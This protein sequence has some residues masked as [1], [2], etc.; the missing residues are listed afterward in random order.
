MFNACPD[1]NDTASLK[2][3]RYRGKDILPMWVAD[4]DFVCAAPVLD[5]LRR[6]NDHGVYRYALARPADYDAV[7]GWLQSR[8][9][10]NIRREWLVWLPGLVPALNVACRA[11]ADPDEEVL[12]FTPV[13]PPFLTAPVLSDRR[14]LTCP[15]A[16]DNGRYTFDLDALSKTV[17]PQTRLLLLCSPHNPVGRVWTHDELLAVADFCL[18]RGI[19]LCSDEIHCDLVLDTNCRHIP[20]ATLSPEIA[21]NTVTLMSPAKTFNLPGLNCG[22]AVIPDESLRR[23]FLRAAQGIL[24][25]VNIMGYTA[26]RAAFNEAGQW[27]QELIVYLRDNHDC[28]CESINAL[29]GLK[30]SPAQATYLAWID[31]AELNLEHP[32]KWFEAAGVGVSGGKEFDGPGFVRLNFGCPRSTLKEALRRIKTA[33][34]SRQA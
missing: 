26:C 7:I 17:T 20:T 2:W 29:P 16:R 6:R 32:A 1:R 9:N 8:H 3:S 14:L 28:L 27:Q 34:E 23:R 22:F 25:H 24:P 18:K 4:M 19:V 12:T 33:L 31:A 11:F 5:A 13:Y 30:M 15:L 10:W 21:A